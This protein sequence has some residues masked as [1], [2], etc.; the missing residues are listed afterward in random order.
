MPPYFRDA[1]DYGEWWFHSGVA[2]GGESAGETFRLLHEQLSEAGACVLV[3]LRFLDENER[4]ID[5][6]FWRRTFVFGHVGLQVHH[7]LRAL[8]AIGATGVVNALK[9]TTGS[10]SPFDV[11]RMMIAS[12]DY[13]SPEVH[14]MIQDLR[15]GILAGA[16]HVL[17]DPPPSGLLP[18]P[19]APAGAE[20]REE[21]GRLL[22]AYCIA[23]QDDLAADAARHGDPRRSVGFDPQVSAEQRARR[24]RRLG[25][26]KRQ[27]SEIAILRARLEDLKITASREA[28]E[29][30]RLNTKV[31][32]VLE[33]Y[34]RYREGAEED[35][36]PEVAAWIEEVERFRAENP[37][38]FHPRATHD[39]ELARRLA[40]I[41]SHDVA[42]DNFS[43]SI[44]WEAPAGLE[45]DGTSMGLVFRRGHFRQR[46]SELVADQAL[47]A[48]CDAWDELRRRWP[49]V[50][51][52]LRSYLI[53]DL[54][55]DLRQLP[56]DE[57]MVYEEAGEISAARVF[58]ALTSSR[59]CLE[60]EPG[61]P[62]IRMA[63]H[64]GVAWDE[65]RRLEI[66]FDREGRLEFEL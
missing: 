5:P 31:R 57:R 55:R 60:S 18:P 42:Y 44:R 27:R 22:E 53:E 15:T 29:S 16:S 34:D 37:A 25:W 39:E 2:L 4:G 63:L 47:R 12:G 54:R 38:P 52:K 14:A 21:V 48:L 13:D 10:P 35:R 41:G 65:E 26:L 19:N 32:K 49:P 61:N 1:A 36:T 56:E 23:H 46:P 62:V 17:G 66:P 33:D 40:A 43:M 30:P 45:C 59:L 24:I 28:P 3:V 64:A 8:D 58:S 6:A 9:G 51:D 50:R 11:A 7:T 20:T